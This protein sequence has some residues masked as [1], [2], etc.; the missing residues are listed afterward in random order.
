M[1]EEPDKPRWR[2]YIA[3][4]VVIMLAMVVSLRMMG[5]VWWCTVG[6]LAPWSGEIWSAHN[7]QHFLDPYTFTHV[8]HGVMFYAILR[9]LLGKDRKPLRFTLAVAL[10]SAWEIAEN[11]PMVIEKYRES[12]VSLDYFGDSVF[13]SIADVFSCMVGFGIA[14]SLPW[15]AT[16]V[17]FLGTEAFLAWWIRDTLLINILMLTFPVEAVKQW[18]MGGAPPPS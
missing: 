1:S 8:L 18:Q 4:I 3:A 2:P 15:W 13:N 11:T 10:E 16:L 6:D 12:T 7:S 5:R 14:A 17:F 9:L